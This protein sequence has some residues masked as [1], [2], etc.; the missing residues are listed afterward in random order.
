MEFLTESAKYLEAAANELEEII[1]QQA[2]NALGYEVVFKINS[3]KDLSDILYNKMNMP[4][5]L[6]TE[7]G[8]PATS[9]LALSKLKDRYPIVSN[10]LTLRSL[11]ST[12][13]TLSQTLPKFVRPDG[14]IHTNYN[15]TGA[16]SGRFASSEPNMQ[17]Q[18]K[19]KIWSV[20]DVAGLNKTIEFIPRDVFVAEPGY[21]LMEL[22]FKQIE[23]LVMAAE[24]G[25]ESIVRAYEQGLDA[26]ANTASLVLR[27][28]FEQI[29][30]E[31]RNKAKT[32][33]YLIIYGGS[34]FRLA[35]ETGESEEK[36]QAD[37]NRFYQTF[38]RLQR[39]SQRIQD[40]ARLTHKV[41]THFGRW[42]VVPEYSMPG[43]RA[44]SKA[45]RAAVNRIIQGTAADI[46][47]MGIVR[48]NKKMAGVYPEG[49][50]RMVAQTH[51]SQTW[52]VH[53]SI[54]PH[55]LVPLLSDA[56]SPPTPNYPRV[57]VD[58]QIGLTWGSVEDYDPT[59]DYDAKFASMKNYIKDR[60]SSLGE[61]I[62]PAESSYREMAEMI[63]VVKNVD[64]SS[65]VLED[66]SNLFDAFQGD[67]KVKVIFNDKS[68]TDASISLDLASLKDILRIRFPL[69]EVSE[70][71]AVLIE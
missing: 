5:L 45:D 63:L 48:A 29:T 41:C 38:P 65:D 20:T 71:E 4:V 3:P 70:R 62:K 50:I 26:H 2:S 17:N 39:Y 19:K 23:F 54:S 58:A 6:K 42:Q 67:K 66:F 27:K 30:K 47:K 7:T 36:S 1:Y 55:E 43:N 57:Q 33:N 25:E 10:I 56:M 31:E 15:Q 40:K 60:L 18:A 16:T 64:Y 44:A 49:Y 22:D 24:A 34:G 28:P 69:A 68:D 8:R 12:V 37:I 32:W 9:E 35:Q 61:A 51:D 21:Y 59:I 13:S 52:E 46:Q 14:R 53:Q 11:R